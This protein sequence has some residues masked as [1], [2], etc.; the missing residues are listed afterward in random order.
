M[1]EFDATA[2]EHIGSTKNSEYYLAEREVMVCVPNLGA[3]DTAESAQENK[4]WQ[5]QFWRDRG[6]GGV[7]V[8]L[9]DRMSGQDK[10]AR[11][12]YASWKADTDN[13]RATALVGGNV[14]SRAMMS[15]FLG[16]NPPELPLKMFGTYEQALH[17]AKEMNE[18]RRPR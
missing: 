12:I 17:W 10:G 13:M 18:A 9:F 8:I 3:H 7:I 4:D 2:M 14:L 11:D 16:L 1:K 5:Q 15:F 6:H